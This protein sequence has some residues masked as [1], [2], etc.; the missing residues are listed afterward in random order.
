M[1]DEFVEFLKAAFIEQQDDAFA[2]GEF[3]LSMLTGT[4]LLAASHFG[5][6]MATAKFRDFL[7]SS[8]PEPKRHYS[9]EALRQARVGQGRRLHVAA[10]MNPALVSRRRKPLSICLRG[11]DLEDVEDVSVRKNQS[12][13]YTIRSRQPGTGRGASRKVTMTPRYGEITPRN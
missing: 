11:A 5:F 12:R 1:F 6:G 9:G 4:P 7:L 13:R 10:G 2:R 3:T 8:H